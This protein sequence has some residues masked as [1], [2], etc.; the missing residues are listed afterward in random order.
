LVYISSSW[1][2]RAKYK[3]YVTAGLGFAPAVVN[4]FG[5]LG[6]DL[7]HIGWMCV[8]QATE[9]DLPNIVLASLQDAVQGEETAAFNARR[10]QH[11]HDFRQLLLEVVYEGVAEWLYRVSHA[12]RNNRNYKK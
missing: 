1:R 3:M 6:P 5:Q 10:G 12:L 11:C 8:A 7:L 2:K 4:T 9:R